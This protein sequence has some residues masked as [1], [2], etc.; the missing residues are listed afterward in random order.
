MI[1]VQYGILIDYDWCTGCYSCDIS[2]QVEHSFPVGQTGIRVQE[3]GPWQIEGEQWQYSF[4]PVPT[5]QCDLCEERTAT[6]KAPTCVKHCQAQCMTYGELE[7]LA[8]ELGKKPKQTLF[9]L[10]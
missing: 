6:G 8:K 3:I 5:D 1:M 10:G 7:K 2:C 9:S 4:L